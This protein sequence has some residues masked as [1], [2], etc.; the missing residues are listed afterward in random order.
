MLDSEVGKPPVVTRKVELHHQTL[1]CAACSQAA[2]LRTR[3]GETEGMLATL[4]SR[5]ELQARELHELRASAASSSQQQQVW[6]VDP[7]QPPPWEHDCTL[8][9]TVSCVPLHN[10][11]SRS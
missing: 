8:T 5:N 10:L 11:T 2:Q 9:A 3:L 1:C 6:G 7:P 4:R